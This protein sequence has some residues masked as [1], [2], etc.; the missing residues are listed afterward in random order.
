MTDDDLLGRKEAAT[1]L[2]KLGCRCTGETLANFAANKNARKGPS[3]MRVGGAVRYRRDDL[4]AWA[5]KR[6]VRV[7]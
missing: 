1:F 3:Y 4:V 7:E 6:T 2:E 5:K